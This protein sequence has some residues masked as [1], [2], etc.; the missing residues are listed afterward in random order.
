MR[1]PM[2]FFGND[3]PISASSLVGT[4]NKHE[5]WEVRALVTRL[6]EGFPHVDLG[7][8]RE[9]PICQHRLGSR[10]LADATHVWPAGAE[11]YVLAHQMWP[12]P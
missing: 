7:I 3:F 12:T 11:H 2:F 5:P 9:C 10:E 1:Q 8:V 6:Q 4:A